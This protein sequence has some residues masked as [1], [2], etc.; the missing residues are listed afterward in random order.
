MPH[1]LPEGGEGGSDWIC[2]IN[3]VRGDHHPGGLKPRQYLLEKS[4]EAIGEDGFP[5]QLFVFR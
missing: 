5:I 3:H 2:G 4:F 1:C